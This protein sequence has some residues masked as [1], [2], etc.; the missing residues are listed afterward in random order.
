MQAVNLTMAQV[1]DEKAE[2]ETTTDFEKHLLNRITK[3]V[4]EASKRTD[5][6]DKNPKELVPI[7][8]NEIIENFL[9]LGSFG[10]ATEVD[11]LSK[12]KIFGIL[13]CAGKRLKFPRNKKPYTKD[14]VR[15][16]FDASDTDNYKIIDKHSK[17]SF[18]F[19]EKCY[20]NNTKILVHCIAGVNRS[21]T[22][23]TAYLI[24]KGETLFNAV[25]IVASARPW[26]LLNQSFN[27]QL[28]RYAKS[29]NRIE[30]NEIINTNDTKESK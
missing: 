11:E 12:R 29:L 9:Y 5:K 21:A 18:E 16:S 10:A 27:L 26:V 4:N 22:I 19:I 2:C 25:N 3:V 28:I 30:N 17:E 7:D 15:Y 6:L 13:N 8:C 1:E 23:V 14:F 24:F 20:Q